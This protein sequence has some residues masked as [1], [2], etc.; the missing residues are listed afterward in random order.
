M[1][2]FVFSLFFFPL[3]I[4]ICLALQFFLLVDWFYLPD[5]GM[6][7]EV[8]YLFSRA[9]SKLA[10]HACPGLWALSNA[11]EDLA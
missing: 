8:P 11:H 9:V 3:K 7:K 10:P 5:F 6:R 2:L 1:Y 4:L